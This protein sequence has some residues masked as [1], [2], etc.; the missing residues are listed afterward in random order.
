MHRYATVTAAAP[1][2]IHTATTV[3]LTWACVAVMYDHVSGLEKRPRAPGQHLTG[4][5]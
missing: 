2:S 5:L 3:L 1:L 4:S